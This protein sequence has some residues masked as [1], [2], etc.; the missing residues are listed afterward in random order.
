MMGSVK[1]TYSVKEEARE[2]HYCI[3]CR[4]KIEKGEKAIKNTW[5]YDGGFFDNWLHIRCYNIINEY[6]RVNK[7]DDCYPDKIEW[8]LDE[9]YCKE[10]TYSRGCSVGVA[11]HCDIIKEKFTDKEEEKKEEKP[12]K[13]DDGKIRPSLVPTQIIKDI[14]LVREYGVKKYKDPE[15]WRK[16]ELGRYIDAFY[17]HWLEFVKDNNSKDEESGLYHYQYCA[18]NLAF[19]CEMMAEGR[20]KNNGCK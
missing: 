8:W 13:K 14:A 4:E 7:S 16:V 19:I 1:F 6:C 15:N 12:A 18:C 20:K 17:R 9:K 5:R 3:L 2:E 10:C 11:L